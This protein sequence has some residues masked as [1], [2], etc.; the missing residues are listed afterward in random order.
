MVLG[1]RES[2][3]ALATRLA[4]DPPGGVVSLLGLSGAAHPDHEVLPS[5]VAGTV[6]LAQ[7]LSDGAV[8][9]PVWT[10]TR[11]GVSATATD[12]VAPT[13][14][15]QVWAVARVAGLEHPEAWG[16]LL[17]LPDRLDDRAA[18]RFAAVLSAGEDE[19]QLALRD[20]GLLARR[21]VRAPVP[22]DAVTAGWQPRDTAL[23]TGGT[24]GLGGQVARWLAARGVRHLVLVSRRGR[25]RRAQTVCATTS[26]PSAYR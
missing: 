26:P 6:L 2:R 9:A 15:A 14:A 4:A 25:R 21:L 16:G 20:A 17:D 5:A 24:G 19:D 1:P 23:V 12:P 7:A 22:R 3:S 13:H 10:L 8:R 18:A 11:N